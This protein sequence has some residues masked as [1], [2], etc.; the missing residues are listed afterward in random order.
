MLLDKGPRLRQWRC[1]SSTQVWKG[2]YHFHVQMKPIITTVNAEWV[3]R[4]YK[5]FTLHPFFVDSLVLNLVYCAVFFYFIFLGFNTF[6]CLMSKT[7][8]HVSILA[9]IVCWISAWGMCLLAI[10][11][12]ICQTLVWFLFKYAVFILVHFKQWLV[13]RRYWRKAHQDSCFTCCFF[14]WLYQASW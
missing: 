9:H 1:L 14:L 11:S 4:S 5:V 7:W 2:L 3:W 6:C 12:C 10:F 8:M 13:P